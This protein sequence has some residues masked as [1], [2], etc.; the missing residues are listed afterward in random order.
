MSGGR[1]YG[2]TPAVFFNYSDEMLSQDPL[3]ITSITC[4]MS[5]AMT[6]NN[7][8]K[9]FKHLNLPY[10][11][12]IGEEDE[13]FDPKKVLSFVRFPMEVVQNESIAHR[14]PE[15]NHL[16]ILLS[17]GA[18]IRVFLEQITPRCSAQTIN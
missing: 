15:E 5:M 12:F 2:N 6:P 17:L 16:S 10:A 14:I 8:K 7:P 9:Q 1:K 18:P 4:N 13:L 11:L 3:L